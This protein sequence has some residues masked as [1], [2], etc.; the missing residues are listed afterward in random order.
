MINK[1]AAL[2]EAAV[3]DRPKITLSVI[4]L[5]LVG[6]AMGLPGFKLDAS[7]ESL[8]LEHDRAIDYSREITARY[9]SGDFLVITY[10]PK[11]PLMSDE[12]LDALK[13]MRDELLQLE[14]IAS[15]NSILD[16]PLLYSPLQ[17]LTQ[18]GSGLRTLENSDVD[19]ELATQEFLE[20]PIYRDTLLSPD[21]LTT[22]LLL[23]FE[24]DNKYLELVRHRDELRLKRDESGLSAE[25]QVELERVSEEFLV[26]RT[27][28]DASDHARVAQVRE[29]T[30]RYKDKAEIF[31]GGVSM[32]T[33]DMIAFI[34]SDLVVFGL[35]ILVFIIGMLVIIFRQP[36]FVFLP[37]ITC[38][39]S[40]VMMLG[41]TSW[42]DW[43]LTV[44]SSNFVAL[45]LIIALAITIHLIVRYRELHAAN[46]DW[47][48]KELVSKTVR[49]MALPCFYTALTTIVA[50]VSLVVSD[51]KPVIDFGWMMTI[52]LCVAFVLAF[53][54]IPAGLM[55]LP[56]GEAKDKGDNS[57]ALTLR[58]SKFAEKHGSIVLGISFVA[59]TA[60][61]YG[62]SNLVVENRFIDYFHKSTEI[63]QGMSAIDQRLGGTI[64]LDIIL[65]VEAENTPSEAAPSELINQENS[66]ALD[67]GV[68]SEVGGGDDD[69]ANDYGEDDPFGEEDPFAYD[70]SFEDD[71]PFGDGDPFGGEEESAQQSSYWFTVAGLSEIK[72][73][74]DYLESLPEIGRVQSLATAYEV[75]QDINKGPLNDFELAVMKQSLP[76]EI[77]D[78]L[79]S[80]HLSYEANQTRITLRAQETNPNLRRAELIEKIRDYAIDDV[81]LKAEQVHFTGLLVLYNNM[82]QSLFRS[83][84]VTMGAVFLGIMVMF[85]V[86]F[87]SFTFSIVAIIPNI[88]AAGFVL[89]SMGI[90]KI[91]LDMMTITIAAITVGVGVDHAIHYIYRFKQEFAKDRSYVQAIHRSH[92][93]IGRAMYYTALTII[94]GFSILAL[95]KF[96]P[97]IYFGLLTGLAMF[98]AILGSLTLLPKLIMMTKPLGKEGDTAST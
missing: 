7:A 51:I 95:S 18:V 96:I 54:I 77:D 62:I 40:V 61:V 93:S 65:D 89:G 14:G 92:A 36:R 78:F 24:V 47:T 10:T 88:L 67:T 17:T 71:D 41:Y 91:P 15:A 83:Q 84:I 30:D 31:L 70:D 81:G 98:A 22:A 50:F 76:K 5:I 80:P 25:E 85:L 42:I 86:L 69:F 79:V 38:I 37:L 8:T 63:Y 56:K 73:L 2:Y 27:E 32:I 9:Q 44:I 20:S 82:L 28:R 53:T 94:V 21:K 4:V 29:I 26:Y 90:A 6:L 58:F 97:S 74:H 87:R 45:L 1:F 39:F 3:I 33:A 48:Q 13:S 12:S 23:N 66:Q 59:A 34:K 72:Q 49:L 75:A 35:G 43:R 52:G 60:S 68:A 55:I 57:A 11:A 46:I 64:T 19:R 16:V